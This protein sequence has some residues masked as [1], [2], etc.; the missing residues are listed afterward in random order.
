MT[1]ANNYVPLKQL[2]NGVTVNFSATWPIFNANYIRV[3]LESVSTGIQ[4]LQTQGSAYTVAFTDAGF[5]VTFLVAPTSANY[6]VIGRSITVDQTVPYKTLQGFQGEIEEGSYDKLTGIVQEISNLFTRTLTFPLGDTAGVALPT[7]ALRANQTLI[8]DALGAPSVGGVTGSVVS[9]PMQPVVS[10]ASLA[11][12]LALLGALSSS[13]GAVANTNLA[14]MTANSVKG[15]ATAGTASPTDIAIALNQ[16]F[17][18]GASGNLGAVTLGTGL[19]FAG[20]VLNA[21]AGGT[22]INIQVFTGSGTYTPTPG[23]DYCIIECRGGGGAAGGASVNPLC[24]TAGGGQGGYARKFASAAT[25]GASKSVTVGTGGTGNSAS[26]G[27]GGGTTSVGAIVSASGGTGGASGIGANVPAL[28]GQGGTGSSGDINLRGQ[29]G[30]NA[31]TGATI[32]NNMGGV[33]G[34]E[35]GG[36]A[37]ILTTNVGQAGVNGGGGGGSGSSGSNQLGASGGDGY[38]IIVEFI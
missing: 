28:G 9:A 12:A 10:A 35:G 32:A 1:I 38:V 13:A 7:A 33:G 19:S 4:T 11:T 25:I 29:A 30:T 27:N 14:T 8:F 31:C 37:G 18:R 6:V 21:A 5:T 20:S 23:M 22:V 16:L 17:G 24:V 34:G 26:T 2:G 3:Y 15:N 36:Q